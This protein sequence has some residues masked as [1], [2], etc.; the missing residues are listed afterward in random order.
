MPLRARQR[1]RS[2]AEAGKESPVTGSQGDRAFQGRE[3]GAGG[4]GAEK[5]GSPG[6]LGSVGGS[7]R[8]QWGSDSEQSGLQGKEML[9]ASV[10]SVRSCPIVWP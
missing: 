7:A 8:E 6:A 3:D 9:E 5:S 4:A 10:A 1:T 2:R